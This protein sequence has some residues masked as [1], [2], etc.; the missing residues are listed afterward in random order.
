MNTS[1]GSDFHKSFITYTHIVYTLRNNHTNFPFR[2][3]KMSLKKKYWGQGFHMKITNR[4]KKKTVIKSCPFDMSLLWGYWT[5][6]NNSNVDFLVR[7][8]FTSRFGNSLSIYR[9]VTQST[10]TCTCRWKFSLTF[11]T[12]FYK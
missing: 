7:R 3:L 1:H 5:M 8:T 4:L 10:H 12:Q 2:I 11:V 9:L 6:N